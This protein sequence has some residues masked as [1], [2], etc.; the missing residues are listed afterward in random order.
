MPANRFVKYVLPMFIWMGVMFVMSTSAGSS[1]VS[2]HILAKLLRQI[3]PAITPS[4]LD[5]FNAVARKM[6]HLTEYAILA[7]LL[8]RALHQGYQRKMIQAFRNS[9]VIAVIFAAFDEFHQSFVASRTPS[10]TD[11]MI[12]AAGAGIGI[13]VLL[14]IHKR[15]HRPHASW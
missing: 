10:V 3:I 14:Y 15:S 11:V 1:T 5:G 12:D 2:E 13:V 8:Y 6:A 4:M 7:V 9:A